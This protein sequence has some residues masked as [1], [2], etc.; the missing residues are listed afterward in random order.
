[1]KFLGRHGGAASLFLTLIT[2]CIPLPCWGRVG[3]GDLYYPLKERRLDG[4]NQFTLEELQEYQLTFNDDSPP[5]QAQQFYL[6]LYNTDGDLP[7]ESLDTVALGLETFL[8]AEL[9]SV[10][11]PIHPVEEVEAVFESQ[12]GISSDGGATFTGSE[13]LTTVTIVFEYE[14]SPEL[15]QLE[16]W[17]ETIMSDLTNGADSNLIKNITYL[18]AGQDPELADLVSAEREYYSESASSGRDTPT[19]IVNPTQSEPS[20][21][22][23]LLYILPTV[24]AGLLVVSMIG[25][26]ALLHHRKRKRHT[27]DVLRSTSSPK[28]PENVSVLLEE[29]SDVFSFEVALIES[30]A[31]KAARNSQ[32][33]Q[34]L[35][36]RT[37]SFDMDDTEVDRVPRPG[38]I[39]SMDDESD[40]FSG[41]H[42][43]AP[44]NIQ[45][46]RSMFSFLSSFTRASAATEPR[47]NL[48]KTKKGASASSLY[49]QPSNKANSG[50]PGTPK[51]LMSSLFAFSE[52]DEENISEDVSGNDLEDDA[53]GDGHSY[54]DITGPMPLE[55]PEGKEAQNIPYDEE[56]RVPMLVQTSTDEDH[57]T[58]ASMSPSE[59]QKQKKLESNSTPRSQSSDSSAIRGGTPDASGLNSDP[60]SPS[61]EEAKSDPSGETPL[62]NSSN[63]AA[64]TGSSWNGVAAMFNKPCTKDDDADDVLGSA[65]TEDEQAKNL[66]VDLQWSNASASSRNAA[67]AAAFVGNVRGTQVGGSDSLLGESVDNSLAETSTSGSGHR[68]RRHAKSMT[69]DGTKTYQSETME[70]T[71]WSL[72]S[73]DYS[74]STDPEAS[75]TI[76]EIVARK[77]RMHR[78]QHHDLD[79]PKSNATSVSGLSVT[80]DG[81]DTSRSSV[82]FDAQPSPS[83]KLMSDLVWLEKKIAG[84]TRSMADGTASQATPKIE[85]ADSMSF[86][87]R[88]EVHANASPTSTTGSSSL[89][90]N[91]YE[92][93]LPK[94]LHSIVCRDCFAPPG[95]LKIV[96]HSTKDG[97]AVHTVKK[98]SSLEGHI[99]P[100]DLIISVDNVDTRSYTAEQVMKLMTA[101]TRSERKITV[102]HFEE[103][104]A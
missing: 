89:E 50:G 54:L 23:N 30:P 56:G 58:E 97:P 65:S 99:F 85:S 90:L 6:R 45:E 2:V 74:Q 39:K 27:E 10:Y 18:D 8:L 71:D 9:N 20:S 81:T 3:E 40:L 36:A 91:S 17:M 34:K 84:T 33:I 38:T 35:E 86:V 103:E 44:S 51:S 46:S 60:S 1:M 43:T 101:K 92:G 26:F 55:E 68:S 11:K 79:T 25:V 14:P 78:P 102:L 31:G 57:S 67:M 28:K 104:E 73:A 88:D 80:T 77:Q 61:L 100:G 24:F 49:M 22:N 13:L 94:G 62:A 76:K 52:E 66:E 83:K 29:D 41:L 64:K 4:T 95:K 7:D 87:S 37:S 19:G 47:S 96:I 72:A 75:L 59:E 16:L 5:K 70:P 53:K 98:G 12:S 93:N 15:S 48:T 63:V 69:A 32:Q 82:P 42:S 21:Q